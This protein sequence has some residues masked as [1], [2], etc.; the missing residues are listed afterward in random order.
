MHDTL[1][2]ILLLVS[3][4]L[5]IAILSSRLSHRAGA[6]LLL[7]VL[8]VGLLAGEDGIGRID[9]DDAP[10]AYALGTVGLALILFDSGFGTRLSTIRLAA[11]PA[12]VLA[13]VGVVLTTALIALPIHF[14]L[15]FNLLESLLLGSIVA[16]TDAAAVFFLL[17]VGGITLRERVRSILEVESG[18]N[19]PMAIFLALM[20]VGL[21]GANAAEPGWLAMAIDFVR[22]MGFGLAFGF[23]G[24]WLVVATVNR[25]D[26]EGGLY[27]LLVALA[28]LAIFAVTNLAHGS[29]YLA[30]YVAGIVAGNN[31]IR[32]RREL[33]R[34]TEG[35]TWL[36]QIAMFMTFGLLATPSEFPAVL[37]PAILIGLCLIFVARPIAATISLAPFRLGAAETAFIGLIG[38]RGAVS[39]LLAILPLLE[40]LPHAR[41]IFNVTFILVMMSLIVQGW[42][43]KPLAQVMKLVVPKRLGPIDRIHLELPDEG[44]HEL[45]AYRL[46][47]DSPLL[48]NRSLPRWVRP[49]LIV[50]DGR[51]IRH[52][53]IG[54]LQAGDTI[55][56]F[57]RP[58]RR[59]LLDRLVASPRA[60][61]KND[62][63]FFGEFTIAPDTPILELAEFYG[64]DLHH[65]IEGQNV[66]DFL[67]R[68]FGPPMAV[69]DR[70]SLGTIELIVRELDERRHVTEVGLS[71]LSKKR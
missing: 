49:A 12:L 47:A 55:Y 19:D 11:A 14:L 58:H 59:P 10:G 56:V 20:L 3:A 6:P 9:F 69:G 18:S 2:G 33:E 24:G 4:L 39:I 43:L 23:A 8:L 21:L 57:V 63:E 1:N 35:L 13:T 29:G 36:A 67:E 5:V 22:Q 17:R 28:A 60:L 16:S 71:L 52:L 41:T 26:L 51:S 46:H 30:V 38:L 34:F 31:R 32:R 62:Q 7:V 37:W 15:G 27:P 65:R 53:R 70:I 61:D 54:R 45:V 66:R 44:A 50:R 40:S 68:E 25:L 64:A 48:T 42:G